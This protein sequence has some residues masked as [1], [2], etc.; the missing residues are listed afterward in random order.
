M[1]RLK[2]LVYRYL[3][4]PLSCTVDQNLPV[5]IAC[6][7]VAHNCVIIYTY[8]YRTSEA[9]PLLSSVLKKT[10]AGVTSPCRAP[11]ALGKSQPL[12]HS[13]ALDN[14]LTK[15]LRNVSGTHQLVC[16]RLPIKKI[17]LIEA[18]LD[19]EFEEPAVQG[20][21]PLNI[22]F[23]NPIGPLRTYAL[24]AVTDAV[25]NSGCLEAGGFDAETSAQ[26]L[27]RP[28]RSWELIEKGLRC[29]MS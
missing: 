12:F 1:Y 5:C 11:F 26:P 9:G 18:D 29:D 10:A 16:N 27:R 24:Q 7:C 3:F 15:A 20:M 2:W 21:D 4:F 25:L 28:H 22:A 17:G 8:R 23:H 6:H 13:M 19:T 14:S